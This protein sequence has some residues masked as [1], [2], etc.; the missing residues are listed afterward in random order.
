MAR[1]LSV[2]VE[3]LRTEANLGR[4]HHYR[5]GKIILFDPA[6]VAMTLTQQLLRKCEGD[7]DE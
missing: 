1:R 5:L 4:I 6:E 3:W 2:P 7:K